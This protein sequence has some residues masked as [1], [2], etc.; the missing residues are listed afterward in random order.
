MNNIQTLIDTANASVA[1]STGVGTSD[2]WAFAYS[3]IKQGV[4]ISFGFILAFWPL[5]LLITV[6]YVGVSL[7]RRAKNTVGRA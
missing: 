1:S 3:L 6:I 2:V 7:S 4:G 5:E